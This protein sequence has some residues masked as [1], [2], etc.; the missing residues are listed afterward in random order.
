M[1]FSPGL[2]ASS[3][4]KKQ[5]FSLKNT[6]IQNNTI[7]IFQLVLVVVVVRWLSL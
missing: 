4:T 1:Y 7:T 6:H 2:L 3:H 5:K